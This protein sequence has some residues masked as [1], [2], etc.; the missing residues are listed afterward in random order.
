MSRLSRRMSVD[1]ATLA[2]G[3]IA[4]LAIASGL[5]LDGGSLAQ[6]LQPTAA[7]I[8]F[9]GT[10]GAVL[11]QFPWTL[12]RESL[13]GVRETL[14]EED[15]RASEVA[16]QLLHYGA[17]ARRGG[18]LALEAELEQIK[19]PFSRRCLMLAIDSTPSHALRGMMGI[20]LDRLEERGEQVAKVWEAAAGFSPTM[21]ILGAVLGLIQVMQRLDD[22]GSV[23]KGI[24][25]AF[26]AT[27]YGVGAA[28]LLFLPVAGKLRLRARAR[29][30]ER[31]MTIDAACLIVEGA[32]PRTLRERL[33]AHTGQST[34]GPVA[35]LVAR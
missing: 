11:I 22:I 26:V 14:A 2:G 32:N 35:K 7:L 9:G 13:L 23:G 30:Q 34:P 1:R 21:G 31:E 29:A 27:L 6:I 15:E 18:L 10:L 24:A 17:K 19:D 5:W 3:L 4:M 25:V 20:E 33:D 12:V 28:N 8:V 16:R